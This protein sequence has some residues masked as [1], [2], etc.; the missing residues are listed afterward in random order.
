MADTDNILNNPKKADIDKFLINP[1]KASK[2]G[3]KVG[4]KDILYLGK[5]RR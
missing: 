5:S 1:K 3:R 4:F 2:T